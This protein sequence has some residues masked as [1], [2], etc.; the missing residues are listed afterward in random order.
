M[1]CAM[2][3]RVLI[4]GAGGFIGRSVQERLA[5]S[6]WEVWTL[7]R[8]PADASQRR[9]HWDPQAGELDAA[10]ADGFDAVV[11]LAGEPLVG[12]WTSHKKRAIMESRSEGTRLLAG[13]L[14]KA[15]HKPSVLVSS[16]AIGYYGSRGDELL[17]EQSGNGSG[18]LA[19]VCERWEAAAQAAREAGIRVVNLRIGLVLGRGG[20]VMARVAPVFRLG[21][22]GKLG[23][24]RQWWSWVSLGDVVGAMLFAIDN[25]S[26]TGPANVVGPAPV[27]NSE[28]TEVLAKRLRRPAIFRV[29]AFAL[30][31]AARELADEMLLASQR[32]SSVK[33]AEAGYEFRHKTLE[34]A[35]SE[36][37]SS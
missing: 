17:D 4:T 2:A 25:D 33:L 22:G 3:R 19:D 9:L 10:D 11:H 35:L 8:A 30:K 29:P 15:V 6:R 31:A 32:V 13:A 26:L 24:G 20:G 1:N 16:G 12:L 7:S 28:F 5:A 21:L 34:D 14:A 36:A 23:D 37:L 27:T 18:F